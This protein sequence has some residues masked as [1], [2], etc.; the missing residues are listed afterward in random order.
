MQCNGAASVSQFMS[1]HSANVLDL[2]LA[3]SS[4]KRKGHFFGFSKRRVNLSNSF[5]CDVEFA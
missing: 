2:S 5:L 3:D 4:A 1:I